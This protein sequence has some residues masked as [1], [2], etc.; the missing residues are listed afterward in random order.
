MGRTWRG[1]PCGVHARDGSDGGD[2][3]DA[4][5][6]GWSTA[7]QDRGTVPVSCARL[8]RASDG[9][10]ESDGSD[11]GKN[12][13]AFATSLLHGRKEG[14][15]PFPAS[16]NRCDASK[17]IARS[18]LHYLHH[19]HHLHHLHHPGSGIR[20]QQPDLHL[21]CVGDGFGAG[22]VAFTVRIVGERGHLL[23]RRFAEDAG[24]SERH[25]C[26]CEHLTQTR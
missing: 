7:Q 26:S 20:I 12:G 16:R 9:G 1:A 2:V 5:K 18:C 22:A 17:R 10:D 3:G 19:F 15:S 8:K 13:C 6:N 11:A 24:I 25:A 4:G 14:Q 23:S 21:C